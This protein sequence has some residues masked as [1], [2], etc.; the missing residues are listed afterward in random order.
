M[1]DRYE[2]KEK[3][4]AATMQ[5]KTS[6]QPKPRENPSCIGRRQWVVHDTLTKESGEPFS[7]QQDAYAACDRL[8]REHARKMREEG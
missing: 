7:N 5:G 6:G 8:N 2:V 4:S 3:R 1:N